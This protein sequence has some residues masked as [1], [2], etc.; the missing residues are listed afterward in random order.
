MTRTGA[1]LLWRS[2]FRN[3]LAGLL[4]RK[5]LSFEQAMAV[6]VEVEG[7]LEGAEFAVDSRAV[8]EWVGDSDCSACGCALVAL[9]KTPGVGPV[10]MDKKLLK[11]FSR[12]ARSL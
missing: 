9:A 8:M 10:T 11:A 6:Q 7:L 2:E 3:T 1:P 4:R 5:S 12:F